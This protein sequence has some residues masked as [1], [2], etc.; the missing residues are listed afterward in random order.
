MTVVRSKIIGYGAYLPEK[1]VTNDELAKTVDTSDE[2]IKERTGIKQRHIAADGEFTSDLAAQ[3]AKSALKSAGLNGSD[4]DVLILGTATPDN[5]FPATSTRVQAH[6]GM[7]GGVAFDVS[8]VC[9]GFVFA[10]SMADNM[11]R[12]GQ[13]KT[14]MVIGAETFSRIIDWN[15]RNTCVLFGDGAGAIIL[16]AEEGNGTIKDQG[17]LSTIIHS[18]GKHYDEL[19][20]NGGVS[21]TKTTG[22]VEMNGREVFRHAVANLV[23]VANE[24]LTKNDMTTDELDW[25]VPHQAN[26][27]IIGSTSRKLGIP[28]EKV[29]TTVDMHANTSAASIPLALYEAVNDGRIKEGHT[30]VVDAMGGGFTWGAGLIRI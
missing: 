22:V 13:A 25:L 20:V 18:D 15:D 4:I 28:A 21:S 7:T 9:S 16:K 14:A 23:S 11:L 24:I 27:R 17:I 3:A 5:T 10:M 19:R 6:I 12:L 30:I 1:I 26:K 29:I 2:W 8:A